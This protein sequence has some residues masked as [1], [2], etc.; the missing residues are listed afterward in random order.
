MLI[1]MFR[2]AALC[3]NGIDE[4]DHFLV[5]F[6]SCKDRLD[7]LVLRHL[8]CACLDHDHLLFCGSDSQGKVG[9]LSLSGS[10]VEDEF[11]V[12]QTNLCR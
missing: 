12:N 3:D 8:V 2:F 9:Y 6:V 4:R 11:T 1:L 5:Q 10:R 7:H